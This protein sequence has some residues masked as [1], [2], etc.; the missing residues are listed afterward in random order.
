MPQNFH[1]IDFALDRIATLIA[2]VGYL[3]EQMEPRQQKQFRD[4]RGYL[5]EYIGTEA[6]AAKAALAEI[7]KLK[8]A[9]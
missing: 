7:T 9:A 5:M 1:R 2:L 4:A 3:D 6:Q 8:V